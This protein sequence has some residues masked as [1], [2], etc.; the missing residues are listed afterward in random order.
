MVSL[1]TVA[2]ADGD[3]AQHHLDR[4]LLLYVRIGGWKAAIDHALPGRRGRPDDLV[5]NQIV[6]LALALGISVAGKGHFSSSGSGDAK[7]SRRLRVRGRHHL[8][9]RELDRLHDPVDGSEGGG[10]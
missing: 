1:D 2:E 6:I 5:H 10:E 8:R 3:S 9:F 7:H 4:N